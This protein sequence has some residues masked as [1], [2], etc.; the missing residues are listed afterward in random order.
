MKLNRLHAGF[1]SVAL[2]GTTV[3]AAHA[4]EVNRAYDAHCALCHQR[5][6]AGLPGQ[7]PRLAGRAG[8]MSTTLEGRHYLIEATLFGMAGKIE[9]DG[10]PIIGVMPGFATLSNEDIASALNYVIGLDGP[11][12][13]KAKGVSVTAADVESARQGSQPS[14]TQVRAN[15]EKALAARKK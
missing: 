6:G 4:T 15:R 10:A 11:T 14:P 5:A 9:V 3:T 12:K 2:I 13:G 7:F 1:L 8:E